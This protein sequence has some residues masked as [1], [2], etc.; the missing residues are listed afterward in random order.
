MRPA[1]YTT[2]E[3][4]QAGQALQ[5]TG[6]NITGFALRKKV[7]GGNPSR[8]KQVWDEYLTDPSIKEPVSDLPIDLNE[9]VVA[10]TKSLT[11]Q[12]AALATVLNDK[13]VKAA[14][15]RVDEV[16]RGADAL[17][18]QT[19]RELADAAQ[20]VDDLETRLAEVKAEAEGLKQNQAE[21]RSTIMAQG[22]ELAQLRERLAAVELSAKTASEQHDAELLQIDHLHATDRS[23]LQQEVEMLRAELSDHQHLD[24]VAADAREE[25]AQLRGQVGVMQTQVADLMRILGDRYRESAS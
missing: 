6:R 17:R 14:E 4:I 19:A 25:A 8:L 13:A 12:I 10:V 18:E 24:K 7:G 22:V 9:E 2:D 21:A 1:E 11:G 5:A 15:R 23:R 20:T 16:A 3:I